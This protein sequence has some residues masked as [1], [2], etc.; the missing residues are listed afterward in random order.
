MKQNLENL[1]N[2]RK[3][4]LMNMEYPHGRMCTFRKYWNELKR[5]SES[6]NIDYVD[7]EM[8][9]KYLDENYNDTKSKKYSEA[10]RSI[11][12]LLDINAINSYLPYKPQSEDELNEYYKSILHDYLKFYKKV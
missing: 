6:K 8:I 7:E 5:Y 1:I 3:E 11:K 4:E 10:I 9:T 12:V 2:L